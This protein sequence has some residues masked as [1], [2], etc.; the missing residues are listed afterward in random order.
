MVADDSRHQA[1]TAITRNL[2]G[3][4]HLDV[5]VMAAMRQVSREDFVPLDI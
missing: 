4:N 3:R 1:G 5:R 2:I